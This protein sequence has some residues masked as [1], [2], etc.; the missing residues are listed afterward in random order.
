M[1]CWAGW[2]DLMLE[3]PRSEAVSR[4]LGIL[5]SG[6][7]TPQASDT[8][9]LSYPPPCLELEKCVL[10]RVHGLLSASISHLEQ[11]FWSL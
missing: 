7:D 3:R 8:L 5:Q 10:S 2:T 11:E 4:S 1:V 9:L 6:D